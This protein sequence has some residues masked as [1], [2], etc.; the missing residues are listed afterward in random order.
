MEFIRSL[1]NLRPQHRGCVA[2]VGNF[3]GMHL[4]HQA[5]IQELRQASER[6]RLPSI[7][8]IFEPQP[9]EFFRPERA[10]ARLMRLREK[11][12]SFTQY[13]VDRTLCLR[14]DDALAR[15]SPRDFV[16]DILVR[17][18]D[19][20]YLVV[21]DD[22]RFGKGRQGDFSMLRELGKEFGFEVERA[23]CCRVC[24]RRISSTWL[25]EILEAG[26]METARKLLGRY[27]AISGRV[28]HGDKRGRDLG[29][30]T[31]NVNLHRLRSPLAGIFAS[32]VHGVAEGALEAVTSVGTRPMFGGKG[33]NLES[34]LFDYAGDAYGRR[35]RIEFFRQLRK[36]RNFDTIK[37]L[38]DQIAADIAQT[39]RFFDEKRNDLVTH[40]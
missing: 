21:G 18:L 34:Y 6:F 17:G 28:V 15:R 7:V 38:Q 14:F 10:P 40:G 8:V 3:D 37:D 20:R 13:Q 5:I 25:R 12:D 9:Q 36:E 22:F 31:I 39:R 33:V 30:P 24:E 35:V 2:T 19:V 4:G 11:L 1:H 32:R 26:D 29:Y 16:L 23:A 27:Y